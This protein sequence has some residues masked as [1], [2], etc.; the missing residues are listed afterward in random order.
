V[1]R[2]VE[3]EGQRKSGDGGIAEGFVCHGCDRAAARPHACGA[4]GF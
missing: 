1:K 4:S 3:G 2:P